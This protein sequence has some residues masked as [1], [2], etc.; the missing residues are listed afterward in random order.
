MDFDLPY[1][2]GLDPTT[3]KYYL[4]LSLML[5]KSYVQIVKSIHLNMSHPLLRRL[6]ML[7][8]DSHVLFLFC[9]G[10]WVC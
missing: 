9:E 2:K 6:K 3:L 1:G 8:V 5:Y 10:F 7:G 4:N